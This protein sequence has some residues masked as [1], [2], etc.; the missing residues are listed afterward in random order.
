MS[1]KII[2]SES[3]IDSSLRRMD[4]HIISKKSNSY[5]IY[6]LG[7]K[8]RVVRNIKDF[9]TVEEANVTALQLARGE[10][11]EE[12]VQNHHYKANVDLVK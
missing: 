2:K 11:T 4:M 10:I 5:G 3:L 12:D 7:N 1:I 6:R 8:Y 9:D